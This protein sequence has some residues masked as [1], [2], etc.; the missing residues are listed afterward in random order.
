VIRTDAQHGTLSY[1]CTRA[2][3]KW[4]VAALR[5]AIRRPGIYR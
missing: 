1:G 3:L 5:E 2:E 4:L